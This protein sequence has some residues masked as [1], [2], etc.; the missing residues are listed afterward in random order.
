MRLQPN[1]PRL[2]T[3][4]IALAIGAI[5][6]VYAWPIDSLVPILDPVTDPRLGRPDDGPRARVSVPVRLS[7]PARGR[8]AV[9]RD[10]TG[11]AHQLRSH[12]PDDHRRARPD[13]RR[14][15]RDVRDPVRTRSGSSPSWSR[16]PSSS[17]GWSSARSDPVRRPAGSPAP[18]CDPAARATTMT[19]APTT[20]PRRARARRS[21]G[22]IEWIGAEGAVDGGRGTGRGRPRRPSC[23]RLP[24]RRRSPPASPTTIA[25]DIPRWSAQE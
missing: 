13:R 5:G 22:S 6:L 10:L 17:S 21:S 24:P 14:T 11:D 4:G 7:E 1:P 8:L 18:R 16:P 15:P 23:R 12:R 20:A 3:V 2:I 19:A 25:P 9:A